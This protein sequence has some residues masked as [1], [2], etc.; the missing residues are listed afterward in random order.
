VS[1]EHDGRKSRTKN[2]ESSELEMVRKVTRAFRTEEPD[3]LEAE[4]ARKLVELKRRSPSGIRDWK[5][6]MA[7]FLYNKAS[8]WVRDRRARQKREAMMELA[9]YEQHAAA[10][11]SR[12]PSLDKHDLQIAFAVAWADLDPSLRLLW[13]ILLE[14]EGNQQAAARRLGKHRNTIRLWISKLRRTLTRHGFDERSG[15]SDSAET[16]RKTD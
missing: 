10:G 4:L 8:N 1:K 12:T 15:G 3:E 16:R 13:A 9:E 7:K 5:A 11:T 14:E 2:V 6:Y